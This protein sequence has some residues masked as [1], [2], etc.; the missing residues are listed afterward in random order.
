MTVLKRPCLL[1]APIGCGGDHLGNLLTP[2]LVVFWFRH[3]AAFAQL[4]EKGHH[5][6]SGAKKGGGQGGQVNQGRVEQGQLPVA[7]K[8]RQ[9]DGQMRK[10]LGEGLNEVALR[11][12]GDDHGVDAGGVVDLHI[13]LCRGGQGVPIGFVPVAAAQA[14]AVGMFGRGRA[15]QCGAAAFRIGRSLAFQG[16]VGPVVPDDAACGIGLPCRVGAGFAGP[17]QRGEFL[18]RLLRDL[19][20]RAGLRQVQPT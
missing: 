9:S 20:G 1:I 8:N 3:A 18:E 15:E 2:I 5:R 11:L 12:F 19:F 10:G 14:Y 16:P 17:A 7:V 13:V 4:I 6:R